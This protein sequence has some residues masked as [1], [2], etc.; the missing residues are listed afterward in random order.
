MRVLCNYDIS[1]FR[2]FLP[3]LT[4][5]KKPFPDYTDPHVLVL[6]GKRP[7]IPTRFEA[8]GMTAMVWKIAKKCWNPKANERPEVNTVLQYL[9]NLADPGMYTREACPCLG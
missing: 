9:E 6:K 5:G 2:S 1:K 8:P 4:T 3:Q 7:S